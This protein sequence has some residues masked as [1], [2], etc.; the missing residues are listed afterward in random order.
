MGYS[1]DFTGQFNLDKPLTEAH[2]AY[3][4]KFSE[5]RRMKRDNGLIEPLLDPLR[6]AAGLP[7]GHEGEYYV[8]DKPQMITKHNSILNYNAPSS[9]QPGLWCQWVPTADY[10]SIMWD[11]GE[12]F[13]NYTEW[14]KYIIQHF[15]QPWGY[16]LNGS[17]D[18]QGEDTND[19]GTIIV[20]NNVITTPDDDEPPSENEKEEDTEDEDSDDEY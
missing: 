15:L 9:T 18:W 14:L 13:Y 3:L 7:V 16:V 17:V 4:R 8:G 10:K 5:T 12:K 1:T 19:H 6:I 2:A 20:V 11:Q